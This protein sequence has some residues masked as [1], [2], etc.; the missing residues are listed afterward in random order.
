MSTTTS[1]APVAPTFG[2]RPLLVRGYVAFAWATGFMAAILFFVGLPLQYLAHVDQVDEI[3]GVVHGVGLYP[4][5]VLLSIAVAFKYRL[6]IPHMA[7]MALAGLLPGLSIY[8]SM[9]TVK[10]IDAK[11][12]ARLAK[13]AAK[14]AA[15]ARKQ[16]AGQG[17]GGQAKGQ[18][19]GQKAGSGTAE[20]PA[21][22]GSSA[23]SATVAASESAAAS[24]A[25]ESTAVGS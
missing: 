22:A 21:Q 11:E 17:G 14:A 20:V 1:A 3:V 10:H 7:L 19:G 25:E 4:A 18:A 8:V 12:E 24:A 16:A 5:Y 13:Q 2:Q 15:R 9:R 6:S 23:E